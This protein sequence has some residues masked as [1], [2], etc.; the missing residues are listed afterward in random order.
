MAERKT[1]ANQLSV[2][3]FLSK[4]KNETRRQDSLVVA[5]MMRRISKKN[6]KMWGPSIIGYD[7]FT[8][9]YADG[10][11]GVL[12]KIGFSPRAQALC[13]YLSNFDGKKALLKRLGKHKLGK[14]QGGGCLYINTLK[15]VDLQVLEEIIENAYKH[16]S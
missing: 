15:D 16:H 6:A 13:F 8:Y 12:C 14:A 10:R 2:K 9:Q 1:I 3:D 7:K 5:K 4:I 11:D